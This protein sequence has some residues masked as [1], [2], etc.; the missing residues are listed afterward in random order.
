MPTIA[1]K[2]ILRATSVLF[3]ALVL[4]AACSDGGDAAA[5]PPAG[6]TPQ[7]PARE[8]SEADRRAARALSI[9]SGTTVEET[10]SAYAQ[11]LLCTNAISVLIDRFRES[12]GVTAEQLQA[13]EQ[14]GALYD[15]QLRSL[16]GGERRTP[17]DVTRDLERTAADNPEIAANARIALGCLQRLQEPT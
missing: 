8:F 14:A 4:S 16:A 9:G 11:A 2:S 7:E 6:D 13:V 10:D 15:R 5:A 1:S 17:D 12:G 3:L